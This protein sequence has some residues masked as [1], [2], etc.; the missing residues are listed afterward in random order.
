MQSFQVP[1]TR[2]STYSGTTVSKDPASTSRSRLLIVDDDMM[3]RELM[4]DALIGDDYTIEEVNNGIDALSA[5]K[6]N[7]P[8]MILLDVNMPGMSGFEVCSEIRRQFSTERISVV[9]VTGLEDSESIEQA[10][11]LGATAFIN[12]PI[13]S[14]TFRYQIQYLLKARNA[15]VELI[16]R[17]THLAHMERISRIHTQ[18]KKK[19]VIL[20][21]NTR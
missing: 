16:E 10:Y 12:K 8:D 5:V 13:N 4:K 21:G 15:F 6:N 20:Q 14:T 11:A 18:S 1:I 17:E 3:M 9:M 19:D 2:D 7:E